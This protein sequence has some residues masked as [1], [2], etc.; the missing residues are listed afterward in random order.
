MR[1]IDLTGQR[2]GR[3]TVI[4]K[5]DRSGNRRTYWKCI[6]DCGKECEVRSSHLRSGSTKSCGCYGI[7]RRS[8]ARRIHGMSRKP[9]YIC[10]WSM[11]E[12]CENPSV[13]N[14]ANYGGRGI[15]VCEEW[16]DFSNFMKWALE[17]GYKEGLTIERID[18]DGNYCPENCRWA[19][20][21]EQANN[22]RNNRRISCNGKNL[23]L[24]EWERETGISQSLIRARI[25]RLGWTEEEAVTIPAGERNYKRIPS[26]VFAIE[27]DGRWYSAREIAKLIGVAAPTVANWYKKGEVKTLQEAVERRDKINSP[28]HKRKEDK[29]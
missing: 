11:I 14:Y 2:F 22:K 27:D 4:G 28:N 29:V 15:S 16:H 7:E 20:Y 12:R 17:N 1:L 26:Y 23:T 24:A 8:E 19:D 9:L 18:V 25:E 5:S 10:H 3:L 21:Q 13:R 6:C